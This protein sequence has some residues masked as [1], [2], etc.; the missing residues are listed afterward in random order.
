[1]NCP[2]AVSEAILE[3]IKLGLLN[4]RYYAGKGDSGRCSVEANHL[5][6]LPSMLRSYAPELLNFYLDI[7]QPE[8]VRDT[9]G[10]NIG[11]FEV[12]WRTLRAFRAD[13]GRS[14]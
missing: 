2:N 12:N 3:I 4:I 14:G 7:E 8:F 13:G 11:S 6:N 10:V 5:H 9:H 1:M